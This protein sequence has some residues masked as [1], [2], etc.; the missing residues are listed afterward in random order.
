MNLR[1]ATPVDAD[2]LLQ[3]WLAY[4]E[5]SHTDDAAG[6][7]QLVANPACEILV[8]EDGGQIIGTVVAAFDG[9]RANVYRLA[10]ATERRRQGIAAQ[11]IA[12]AEDALRARGA[13][14]IS[15]IV[16]DDHDYAVA[17][18]RAAGY[19]RQDNVGRYVKTID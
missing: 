14:R 6:V 1:P 17:T 5:P 8:A 18:W 11:L 13:R 3:F 15:A 16:I 19:G 7:G 10:V 9:W 12:A 4:A 2:A